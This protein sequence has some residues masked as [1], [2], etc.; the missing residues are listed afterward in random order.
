MA[1]DKNFK[2]IVFPVV[3]EIYLEK[4]REPAEEWATSTYNMPKTI[5]AECF[6]KNKND[7]FSAITTY[8]N[9]HDNWNA[10]FLIRLWD[11]KNE[12]L[13]NYISSL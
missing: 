2:E 6:F 1:N 10:G 3:K 13:N 9:K 11:I 7:I 5:F 4:G 8:L 12:E